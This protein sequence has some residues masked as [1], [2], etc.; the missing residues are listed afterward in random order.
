MR[1]SILHK[2]LRYGARFPFRVGR[3]LILVL[4]T[5][6]NP[7]SSPAWDKI[8]FDQTPVQSIYP[9]WDAVILKDQALME[10]E[11]DGQAVYTLHRIMKIF[12]DPDKR[13]SRQEIPFNSSIRVLEIKAR[14]IHPDGEEFFLD[15]A[16]IKEK[17][18]I[19]EF[20]LYSDVKAKE[21]YLPRV[22]KDCVVEYEY[23]LRL[24][25]LLYWSDWFFQSDLPSLYSAYTLKVPR[26]F[27]FKVKVLNA[28]IEPR[29]DFRDDKQVF[30]WERFDNPAIRKEVFMPPAAD[31]LYRVAFSPLDFNFDGKTYPSRSWYDIAA[32]YRDISQPSLE[33]S[34]KTTSL[35][36]ELTSGLTSTE[37]K[38]RAIFDYVQ[39]HVRYVSVAVGVGAYRP[40]LCAD[41]MEYGY[42]DCK[43]MTSLVIGLLKAVQIEAYPALLSTRG[44]PS[45][46]A[47]MARVK[48][49]D[50]VVV[51]VPSDNG[52]LWLDLACRDCKF[53]QLPFEDQGATALIVKPNIGELVVT[54]ESAEEENVAYT[55]WEIKLNSDGSTSGS[56][57]IGATGQEELAF[58]ASLA[59][60]KPPR[61]EEA[62]NGFLGYW[63]I[64]P[65]LMVS[66]FRHF[67]DRDSNISVRADFL[68]EGF[69][70]MQK[71]ELFLPVNLNTQDYLSLVF[72]YQERINP[73]MFDYR[74]VNRDEMKIHIPPQFEIEHLPGA[75]R[76]D[77]PFGTFESTFSVEQDTI[78]HKRLFVRK[79]LLLSEDLYPQLKEFYDR[80]AQED[81]KKIVLRR[82]SK[83]E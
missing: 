13:Y 55:E 83:T 8:D 3:P 11:S 67:E 40:H 78:I 38:V 41:V 16:D 63:F 52:Y 9:L 58:R 5:L 68:S 10:I 17:S 42:G 82:A 2:S 29:I 26:D 25:S 30:M 75:V 31:S 24:N 23:R 43:D 48:Q 7:A 49:F 21:F 36:V 32:W 76:L 20:T 1:N 35:A 45:P 74:F 59:R 77:E 37:A 51:V 62:L 54:P 61:R 12:S 69:G 79:D 19:S 46:L 81:G 72:P 39:E 28:F 56:L 4:L 53:G 65:D 71:D 57:F 27:D 33:L 80:A 18:L 50:H 22:R 44:H 34:E 73:V 60:L 47:G 64:D 14:T 70:V 6:L 66:E 15:Q